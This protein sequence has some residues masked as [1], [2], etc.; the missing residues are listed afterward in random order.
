MA[1]TEVAIERWKKIPGFGESYC[2]SDQGSVRRANTYERDAEGNYTMIPGK[3][4]KGSNNGGGYRAVSLKVGKK[5]KTCL[6]HRLVCE[7]FLENPKQKP[8]V[9]HKNGVKDDNRLVNLEWCTPA[10]NARHAH[11]LRKSLGIKRQMKATPLPPFVRKVGTPEQEYRGE[12]VKLTLTELHY[13][14]KLKKGMIKSIPESVIE[15]RKRFNALAV[16]EGC[17]E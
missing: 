12:A 17:R 14:W 13:K 8:H 6:V 15:W 4:L 2:V 7:A 9:N 3:I 16:P 5:L 11:R 10:E 1:K